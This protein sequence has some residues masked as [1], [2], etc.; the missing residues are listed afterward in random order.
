MVIRRNNPSFSQSA[1]AAVVVVVVVQEWLNFAD[2]E[3][4][5]QMRARRLPGA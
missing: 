4:P 5:Q 1:A 3:D 2:D